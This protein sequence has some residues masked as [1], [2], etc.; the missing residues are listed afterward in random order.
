L[1]TSP[2]PSNAGGGLVSGE[3]SPDPE[4]R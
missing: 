1:G 4:I 2:P 3:A